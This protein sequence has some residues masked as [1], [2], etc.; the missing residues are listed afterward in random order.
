M[1]QI[2]KNIIDVIEDFRINQKAPKALPEN[3]DYI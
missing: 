1:S 3:T 2:E